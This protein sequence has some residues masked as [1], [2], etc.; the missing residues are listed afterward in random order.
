MGAAASAPAFGTQPLFWVPLGFPVVV[1]HMLAQCT[2]SLSQRPIPGI[3]GR[4]VLDAA[5]GML[6]PP[7]NACQPVSGI[8]TGPLQTP[9][10]ALH[11]SGGCEPCAFFWKP[12]GCAE[13]FRCDHCH[14]CPDGELKRRKKEKLAEKKVG[15]RW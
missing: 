1:P 5:L 13:G 11:G 9:G 4:A 2:S 12:R 6:E 3:A 8:F 14:L 7:K 10:S 15:G